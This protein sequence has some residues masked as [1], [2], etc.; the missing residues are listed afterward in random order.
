MLNPAKYLGDLQ[1]ATPLPTRRARVP[2]PWLRAPRV[3]QVANACTRYRLSRSAAVTILLTSTKMVDR[4]AMVPSNAMAGSAFAR[5]ERGPHREWDTK[6]VLANKP[7]FERGL[8]F[9]AARHK[10]TY[11][12]RLNPAFSV[13]WRKMRIACGVGAAL[14]LPRA[15]ITICVGGLTSIVSTRSRPSAFSHCMLHTEL[16]PSAQDRA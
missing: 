14:N 9:R 7:R 1:R 6:E 4:F 5:L 16:C 13:H 15:S 3:R 8:A 11:A 2:W 10:S 12:A